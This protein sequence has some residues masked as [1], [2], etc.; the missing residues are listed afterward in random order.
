MFHF[1]DTLCSNFYSLLD[2][3]GALPYQLNGKVQN[4]GKLSFPA[5]H[6]KWIAWFI[7][8][9]DHLG[10]DWVIWEPFLSVVWSVLIQEFLF[11]KKSYLTNSQFTSKNCFGKGSQYSSKKTAKI[12]LYFHIRYQI[13]IHTQ[14]I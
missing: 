6:K 2:H 10:A 1:R 3:F 5:I 8:F 9:L 7:L 12:F 13:T 4:K 14:D 11:K